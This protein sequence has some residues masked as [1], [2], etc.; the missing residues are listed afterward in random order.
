LV[1]FAAGRRWNEAPRSPLEAVVSGAAYGACAALE[2]ARL[3]KM[4]EPEQSSRLY[5]EFIDKEE[6]AVQA[7]NRHFRFRR[8]ERSCPQVLAERPAGGTVAGN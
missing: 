1:G 2:S 8:E 5:Q 7:F 6:Q 3:E 4:L